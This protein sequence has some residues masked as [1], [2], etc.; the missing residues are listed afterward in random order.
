MKIALI[1]IDITVFISMIVLLY[2]LIPRVY[3][4]RGGDKNYLDG[5]KQ[6]E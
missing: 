1:I 3:E 5:K 4:S 2:L 6:G